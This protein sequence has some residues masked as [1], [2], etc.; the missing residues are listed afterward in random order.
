[1]IYKRY[2]MEFK[3]IYRKTICWTPNFNNYQYFSNPVSFINLSPILPHPPH[4]FL[5]FNCLEYFNV[6]PGHHV[7]S[8]IIKPLWQE[9][10]YIYKITWALPHLIKLTTT[11]YHVLCSLY[12]IFPNCLKSVLDTCFLENTNMIKHCLWISVA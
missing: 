2:I 7:I 6:N 11:Q 4:K 12:S 9:F 5:L 8:A 3:K 10:L 1:M